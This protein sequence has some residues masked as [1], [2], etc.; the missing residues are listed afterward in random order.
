MTGSLLLPVRGTVVT[1]FAG[2][3]RVAERSL[4]TTAAVSSSRPYHSRRRR[5]PRASFTPS[6]THF[7][8]RSARAP[9][10]PWQTR[11]LAEP[12]W[13]RTYSA[14]ATA[15]P[16]PVEPS[17]GID[18]DPVV[19]L[20]KLRMAK[21]QRLL[22]STE[23]VDNAEVGK[24]LKEL[25]PLR[26]AWETFS[27]KRKQL[28]TTLNM[29]QN[30]PD[31][32]IRALASEEVTLLEEELSNLRSDMEALILAS[33][34][35]AIESQAVGAVLEVRPG[36]GGQESTLFTAEVAR[37]YERFCEQK[38]VDEDGSGELQVEML[39]STSVDV[40]TSSSG[41]GAGLKEAIIEVKGK[42]VFQKL[43]FEA[44]VH[45]V[46]RIPSTQSL[47]K[48]QTSTIAVMVLPISEGSESKADDLVDPKDVKVEVMRSRGAGGQHVNKTE[49]AIRLTH[50]PTGISVSM[51]DSRSQ[52][53]NR[54]KA[55]AVLR[56]RLLDRKLKQE[57]EGNRERRLAQVASMDRS[58]RVRTYN[59]P[60]DRVT[61]HRI[62]LSLNG[63]DAIME[64]EHDPGTGLDHIMESLRIESENRKIKALLENEEVEAAE[65]ASPSPVKSRK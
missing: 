1:A 59:F 28:V 5:Q 25:D 43:K 56:A 33:V 42:G 20:A 30:D 34:T 55:W 40:S 29:R 50:E 27:S 8:S 53:Q 12:R 11:S 24:Q 46:Q 64:G 58:D 65:A 31:E 52:H 13:A 6:I 36:V 63:I 62:N 47:G 37:M 39:S 2:P 7:L 4:H 9:P 51:Q 48:L 35:D 14:K 54:T 26:Q 3:S 16:E 38:P 45:R 57:V 10:S 19:R 18:R 61:D 44:G 49:S 21:R 17:L 23:G 32:D 22:E 15:P 41:S 60:Q